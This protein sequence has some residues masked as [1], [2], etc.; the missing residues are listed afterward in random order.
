MSE[1]LQRLVWDW[2]LRFFHWSLAITVTVSW[3]TGEYGGIDWRDIHFKSGYVAVGLVVFRLLWGIAGTRHSRFW[4]FLPGPAAVLRKLRELPGRVSA[5]TA[6]HS[7]LGALASLAMITAVG[8]QAVSGLYVTDDILFDGPRYAA[9]DAATR[10]I[11]N[12]IHHRLPCVLAGLVLLHLVA[13]GYYTLRQRH[14]L[15]G[16]MIHGKKPADIVSDADA[17]A[18]SG[19]VRAAVVIALSVAVTWWLVGN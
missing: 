5:Q 2:P 16:P 19:T 14:S 15:I 3:V 17:I 8:M 7:A 11:M 13:I 18:H 10:D 12:Q 4:S 9:A 1:K 6:G